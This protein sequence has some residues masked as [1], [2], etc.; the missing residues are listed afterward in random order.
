MCLTHTFLILSRFK[1]SPAFK[2]FAL[3]CSWIK[4]AQRSNSDIKALAKMLVSLE[5]PEQI[6]QMLKTD[7]KEF[8]KLIQT[9]SNISSES[10]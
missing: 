9:I 10:E 5:K 6:I 2:G 7:P 3:S 1:C 8:S 4:N